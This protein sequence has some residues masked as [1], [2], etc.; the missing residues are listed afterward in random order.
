MEFD[1]LLITTGVDALIRLIKEK[2]EVECTDAATILK[3][4]SSSVQEWA[5]I[6]EEEGIISIKYKYT[7]SYFA[8]I[9]PTA[10]EVEAEKVSFKEEKTSL[11]QEIAALKNEMEPDKLSIKEAKEAFSKLYES[12]KPKLDE[13]HEKTKTLNTAGNTSSTDLAKYSASIEQINS[14]LKGFEESI[15]F[16]KSQLGKVREDIISKSVSPEEISGLKAIKGEASKINDDL[17]TLEK[18]ALSVLREVPQDVVKCKE[19]FKEVAKIRDELDKTREKSDKFQELD[20]LIGEHLSSFKSLSS[21]IEEKE[22]KMEEFNKEIDGL[23][24]QLETVVT[25]CT[26]LSSKLKSEKQELFTFS[27]SLE[28]IRGITE[29]KEELN[30]L[31]GYAAELKESEKKLSKKVNEVSDSLKKLDQVVQIVKDFESLSKRIDTKRAELGEKAAEVFSR[32]EEEDSTYKLFQTIKERAISSVEEYSHQLGELKN[33]LANISKESENLR[34]QLK[35]KADEGLK[36][37]GGEGDKELFAK[38]ESLEKK[39]N[40]LEDTASALEAL[41]DK[42]DSITKRLTLLSREAEFIEIRSSGS[43]TPLQEK[44][45]EEKEEEIRN[46]ITLTKEEREEFVKKRKE[47]M[48]MVK[49]LWEES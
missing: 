39:A 21:E 6:L 1:D 43:S 41:E 47:L 33:E 13:I 27:K 16:I 10:E 12:I 19:L 18:R 2:K 22:M 32:L 29:N 4:P 15:E 36:G 14:K 49:K 45:I 9:E 5:Q 30:A 44:E 26:E 8:W 31:P 7:K 17:G 23:T 24:E 20:E 28:V 38:I 35:K 48:D 37:L 11:M 3:I 40:M 34:T 46:E 25:H 42:V